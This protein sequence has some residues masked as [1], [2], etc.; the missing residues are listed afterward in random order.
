MDRER[1]SGGE[2]VVSTMKN[3]KLNPF[4]LDKIKQ[5]KSIYLT[6]KEAIKEVVPALSNLIKSSKGK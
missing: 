4:N 5:A 3:N 6:S 1:W 2:I